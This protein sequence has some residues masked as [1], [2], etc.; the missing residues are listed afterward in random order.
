MF[1]ISNVG[2]AI[3]DGVRLRL[4]LDEVLD[5]HALSDDDLD[6]QLD[7]PIARIAP[8]ETRDFELAVKPRRT[9][10]AVSTAELL[11][12]DQQLDLQTFRLST[13]AASSSTSAPTRVRP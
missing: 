11:F 7:A 4:I 13:R 1:R 6:R 9:G 12:G 5:H 8:G 3:A 10:E 2:D